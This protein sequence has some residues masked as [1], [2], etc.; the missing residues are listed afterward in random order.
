MALSSVI[1]IVLP[2]KFAKIDCKPRIMKRLPQKR[3]KNIDTSIFLWYDL[4]DYDQARLLILI[5]ISCFLYRFENLRTEDLL[6]L[7]PPL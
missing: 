7:G 4:I 1:L 3:A 5:Y 2:N 6:Q